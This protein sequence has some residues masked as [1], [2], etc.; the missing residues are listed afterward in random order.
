MG[1]K[2]YYKVEIRMRKELLDLT[3]KVEKHSKQWIDWVL[4]CCAAIFMPNIFL[5]DLY[6]RNRIQNHIPFNPTL[7]VAIIFAVIS[8]GLFLLLRWGAR[9]SEGALIV[10]SLFW[11]MFWLF[12]Q[13]YSV[14]LNY[15]SSL[16]REIW[17]LF[18]FV[19]LIITAACFRYYRP[20]FV[21]VSS[22]FRI[23]AAVLC[24]LFLF[25]FV[26]AVQHQIVIARG[27]RAEE[28]I[29]YI[30]RNFNIDRTLPS[31]DIYWFHMDG[32]MSLEMAE[33]FFGES[34]DY[35]REELTKRGFLMYADAEL[36]AGNTT[37]A[38]PAL[39]S[40]GFYD[41]YFGARLEEV[42]YLL[43]VG[44]IR[45]STLVDTLARDGVN[46]VMDIHPYS[47]L[48]QAFSSIN[49]SIVVMGDTTY[50]SMPF[51]FFYNN[52]SNIIYQLGA[53]VESFSNAWQRFLS[54]S[55][56]LAELI[57][58]MTPFSIIRDILI[59]PPPE[60]KWL[61]ISE[62]EEIVDILLTENSF[63]HSRVL[64][65][66]FV[67]SFSISSPKFVF[68]SNMFAHYEFWR[69]HRYDQTIHDPT[70]IDLYVPS[71]NY[72]VTTML[73]KIDLVIN[74]NPNAII[75]LQSD[76]GIH[77]N[78]TQEHL[79]SI[80]YTE[81]EVH[82]LMLSVFSA[83]RIPEQYGG[84]D[85]P[86]SPLNISRELVNRFVGPNYTLLPDRYRD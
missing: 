37:F 3:E 75:I 78:P 21:K 15:S 40:P 85:A 12:E 58:L 47:E 14:V 2:N 18:I 36:K 59:I 19:G 4:Y 16:T 26:P 51:N 45:A 76:H 71:Y 54:R 8:V 82:E 6:N 32:M 46:I 60:L 11:L 61:S 66:A 28:M 9:S 69:L 50:L 63:W 23:L 68:V 74:R 27:R 62:H 13:T 64:Y 17:L 72:A 34:Q 77:I 65:R 67:D 56:D 22:V 38:L 55:S 35:L 53:N 81:E 31:P 80:G 20:P 25:N 83:V 49:Y 24:G 44:N 86:L 29:F 41:S 84:L 57:T 7:I 39:L 48:L 10:I 1:D 52:V 70:R 79:L 33:S 5:F 73:N 30:K 42:R 43:N